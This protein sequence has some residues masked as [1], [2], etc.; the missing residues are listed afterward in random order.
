MAMKI[1]S[2]KKKIPSIAN[3]MPNT[4]PKRSIRPGQSSPISNESTVP[5]TAPT[6]N[7]T[8]ITFDQ[9]RASVSATSSSLR[10]PAP[11]GDQRDRR[12]RHPQARQD[13]VEAQREGHLAPRGEQFG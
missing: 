1:A 5:V 9:R 6:A 4:S 11:V 3:G 10:R 13:D 7:S 2:V 12:E 8:A